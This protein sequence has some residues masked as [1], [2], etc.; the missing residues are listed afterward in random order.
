MDAFGIQSPQPT[1]NVSTD[2]DVVARLGGL[3]APK[4]EDKL[5]KL[6]IQLDQNDF[7]HYLASFQKTGFPFE[8][9]CS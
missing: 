7:K 5:I 4:V 8:T 9:T 1:G 2:I 6:H 3:R